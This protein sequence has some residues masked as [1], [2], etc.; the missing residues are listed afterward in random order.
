MMTTRVI[1]NENQHHRHVLDALEDNRAVRRLG[2][3][4]H[5]PP[6][7][8]RLQQRF[9]GALGIWQDG[10]LEAIFRVFLAHSPRRKKQMHNANERKMKREKERE[11]KR[12]RER[13]TNCGLLAQGRQPCRQAARSSGTRAAGPCRDGR[14]EE[15]WEKNESTINF[16]DVG[17]FVCCSFSLCLPGGTCG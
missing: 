14:G 13:D 9:H 6:L 3:H 2:L 8:A 12:E 4:H 17:W 10:R 7:G 15:E 1:K 5:A 11:R 16:V